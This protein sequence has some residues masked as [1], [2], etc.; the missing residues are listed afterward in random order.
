MLNQEAKEAKVLTMLAGAGAETVFYQMMPAFQADTRFS[1]SGMITAW[2]DLEKQMEQLKPNLLVV[3]ADLA[4]NPDSLMALLA[5]MQVWNGVALVILQTAHREFRGAFEKV[6]VVRGVFVL[7]VNWGEVVQAGYAA[8]STERAR[9]AAQAPLQTAMGF[10]TAT[11]VTGTRVVAFLSGTGGAGRST[12]AE[13]IAYELGVRLNVRTL[14]MSMG[15]PPSA[16]M[17]LGLKYTPNAGEFFARPGDGFASAIQQK[18]GLDVIMAPENSVEYARAAESSSSPA[19]KA[20]ANSIYS[21]VM[22]SWT[23]SYAAVLLDLPCSEG[24]WTMHPLMAANTAI[25]VSRATL[26]D[27]A[28]TR[29]LL[30]LLMERMRGEHRIPQES[31]FMVLNQVSDGG[32][33][34]PNQFYQELVQS[35]GWA[36]PI[37]AVI[38]YDRN[39]PNVQDDRLPV[40]GKVDGFTKGIRTIINGLFPGV[41]GQTTS[42]PSQKKGFLGSLLGGRG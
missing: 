9:G 34:P 21:L 17:N 25:I 41:A 7:P 16:A 23:R 35:Y 37:L 32:R 22:A 24:I 42:D 39:I 33:I 6:G 2:S 31:I 36:P 5:R 19:G 13:N 4:P 3:Q 8:V 11:S 10:R 18:E 1:V 12:L 14:L 20:E 15:L 29:H 26:A 40:A 38:P 30:V 27:L 28:A